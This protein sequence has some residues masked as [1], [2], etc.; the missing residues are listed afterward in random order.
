MRDRGLSEREIRTTL[1]WIAEPDLSR[2][3]LA[4]RLDVTEPTARNLLNRV[5]RKLAVGTGRGPD[6]LRARIEQLS[7]E[8]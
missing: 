3:E 6:V 2:A 1:L 8:S 5:R 7:R 4:G